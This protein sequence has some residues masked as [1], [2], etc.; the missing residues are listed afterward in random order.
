MQSSANYGVAP[1]HPHTQSDTRLD[2]QEN[3]LVSCLDVPNNAHSVAVEIVLFEQID[4]QSLNDCGV[5]GAGWRWRVVW[6]LQQREG[7]RC[8][9]RD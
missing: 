9:A 6:G 7:S 1:L 4:I 3:T 8:A 2:R 5:N